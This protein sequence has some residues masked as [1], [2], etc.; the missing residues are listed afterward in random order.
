MAT[1]WAIVFATFFGP[2]F[3]VWASDWREGRR[4]RRQKREDILSTLMS[5]RATIQAPEHVKALNQIEV[6]YPSDKYESVID[7][8]RQYHRHLFD[9]DQIQRDPNAWENRRR[10]LLAA[11]ID[12]CARA[13]GRKF[14]MDSIRNAAYMPVGW[15]NEA[16]QLQE[17]RQNFN[18]L[19]RAM[20]G[21][22][23]PQPV[24]VPPATEAPSP[25]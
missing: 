8:W 18:N 10:D 2:I 3:A 21:H 1:D 7:S 6:A 19:M 22:M 4:H 24:G 15:A 17:M 11:L 9:R 16:A 25:N 12:Q 13:C 14:P 23:Q 20:A 5:T